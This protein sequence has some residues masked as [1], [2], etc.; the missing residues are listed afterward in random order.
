MGGL[1]GVGHVGVGG[2]GGGRDGQESC[3]AGPVK[4]LRSMLIA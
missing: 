4:I 3:S 1:C 2:G